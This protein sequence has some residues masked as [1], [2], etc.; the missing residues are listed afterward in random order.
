MFWLG[1][2]SLFHPYKEGSFDTIAKTQ[3]SFKSCIASR[4][5]VCKKLHVDVKMFTH[6]NLIVIHLIRVFRFA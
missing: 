2:T 1:P 4:I 5:H 3:A 6:L